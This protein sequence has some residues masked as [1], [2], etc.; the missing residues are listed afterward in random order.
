MITGELKSEVDRIWNT[1]W[2]GGISNPLPVIEQ[3]TYLL[4]IKGLDELRTRKE[5][6]PAPAT[7]SRSRCLGH[8]GREGTT[9]KVGRCTPFG[10]IVAV[11]SE[12]KR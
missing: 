1:M 6:P 11:A 7:R 2:S 3:L 12:A 5:R 4:F 9:R 8:I 10:R